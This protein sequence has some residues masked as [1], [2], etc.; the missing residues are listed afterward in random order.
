MNMKKL[1]AIMVTVFLTLTVFCAGAEGSFLVVVPSGA[2]AMALSGIWAENPDAVKTI[3]ADTIAEAFGS[4]EADFIIAPINAGAKLFKAGKST[5][6]L[7]AVVTWGNLVFASKEENFVPESI[8]GKKLVL[9][10]ENTIN[11]SIAKYVLDQ[12]GIVPSETEYLAGAAETQALLLSSEPDTVVMTAEPAITAAKSKDA[13]IISFPLNDLYREITGF[14]GFTQAGLFVNAQTAG[15]DPALVK[16][17]LSKIQA[18]VELCA[19]DPGTVAKT[20]VAMEVLPAEPVA[21]KAL[22]GC[23]IR[24]LDAV[25]SRD[26]IEK[27]AEID[28]QQ[29]GGELPSDDFYFTVE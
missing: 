6:R 2:P 9:F 7:A 22:P 29:F 21:L 20:V 13:S 19:A 5:Y 4:A 14:D 28:L 15:K 11:A 16:E 12:K 8:N 1:I 3:N 25:T 10:G 23:N 24:W 26:Q 27:T 18:S 17:A